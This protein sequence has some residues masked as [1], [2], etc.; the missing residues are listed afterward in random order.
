MRHD[1]RPAGAAHDALPPLPGAGVNPFRAILDVSA[2]L[3]DSLD[4]EVVYANTAQGIGEAMAVSQA[5]VWIH[6]T[7]APRLVTAACWSEAGTSAASAF[8]GEF[9]DLDGC[10]SLQAVLTGGDVVERHECDADLGPREHDLIETRGAMTMLS[11]PLATGGEVFGLLALSVSRF[12]R[13]FTPLELELLR[14][15]CTMAA[16]SIHHARLYR[17][18]D[19]QRRFLETHSTP[20][21]RTR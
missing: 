1:P 18:M 11:A 15:L 8:A 16:I 17:Q 19:E 4:L 3:V 12:T 2:R 20:V 21:R 9:V 5:E 6:E 14:Q 13:R 10:P 7:G